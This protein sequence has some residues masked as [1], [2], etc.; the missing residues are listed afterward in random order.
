MFMK[1]EPFI[2]SLHLH[3]ISTQKLAAVLASDL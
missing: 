2:Y 1:T 3:Y